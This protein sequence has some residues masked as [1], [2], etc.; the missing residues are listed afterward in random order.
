MTDHDELR[1][2]EPTATAGRAFFSRGL[3]GQVVMLNLLRFRAVADYTATPHLAP[4]EPITGAQAYA[5]Y[6]AH[7]RPF[8]EASGGELV[9]FGD[10]GP[11]LI[12]PD[13]ERWDA[14]MLVRQRSAQDF[15][16]FATNEAYLA[17]MG[18]RQAALED[19]RLLPLVE[20][21]DDE[22]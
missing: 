9:F 12:G 8:L 14:A 7:T 19:S 6:M 22:A 11:W 20:R 17:G 16:A 4:A 21:R 13:T 2:I 5:R 18:H 3:Q 10:G 15:L 1:Y